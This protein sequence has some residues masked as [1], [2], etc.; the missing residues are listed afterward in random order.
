MLQPRLEEQAD[1]LLDVDDRPRVV[2]RDGG[3]P[4]HDPAHDPVRVVR[5]GEQRELAQGVH[6]PPG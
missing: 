5:A 4:V 3:L 1:A 6:P 2:E